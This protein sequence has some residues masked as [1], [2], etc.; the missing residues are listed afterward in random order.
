VV[1]SIINENTKN[2]LFHSDALATLAQESFDI[3]TLL[4]TYIE[5]TKDAV[6]A[7]ASDT[8][9]IV[10]KSQGGQLEKKI[11]YRIHNTPFSS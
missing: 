9:V 8:K 1:H 2:V 3:L 6:A 7:M 4:P 11:R 10:F 5:N